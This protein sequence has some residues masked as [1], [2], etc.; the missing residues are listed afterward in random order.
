MTIYRKLYSAMCLGAVLLLFQLPASAQSWQENMKEARQLYINGMYQNAMQVFQKT[1]SQLE[2]QGSAY[3][4]E[5]EEAEGYKLLCALKLGLEGSGRQAVNYVRKYPVSSLGKSIRFE[6]A[7]SYFREEN[8][9]RALMLLESLKP[10][11]I[12]ANE[13]DR[14]LLE[15]GICLMNEGRMIEAQNH[16]MEVQDKSKLHGQAQ[17][18]L[19]FIEYQEGR[20]AQAIEYFN[21]VKESHPKAKLMLAECHFMLKDYPYVR[22]HSD[23]ANLYEGSEKARFARIISESAFALGSNQEAE[24][25]FELYSRQKEL[26]KTDAFY[27]G[28]IAYSQGNWRKAASLFEECIGF[29]DSDSLTQNALY[30]LARCKI[31][32]KDKVAAA[33]AFQ[34]ASQMD[35]NPQV[36]EDA[37]FNYAK[38]S[39]DLWGNADNLY[40]Y[41][42]QYRPDT[43]KKDETYGYIAAK[44]LEENNYEEAI[45]S[46]QMISSPSDKDK[47]NLQ[48]ANFFQGIDL[49]R[50]GRY[51][52]SVKYLED[53][54]SD[55]NATIG[56]LSSYW[57]AESLFRQGK[58]QESLDILSDLQ[59]DPGF[60]GTSEYAVSYFN[61]GYDRLRLKDVEG[62]YR[63]F[64]KYLSL[65]S[66]GGEYVLEARLRQ[67][68]CKFMQRDFPAASSLYS[69]ITSLTAKGT[70]YAPLQEAVS[71]GLM[72]NA[73]KKVEIL[74]KYT[75]DTYRNS[76]KFS[77][78][79][80][81][82]GRTQV[83]LADSKSAEK[84]FRRLVE[85]PSDSLFYGKALIE[86]G[87]L[88][89]NMSDNPK[90]KMY[91]RKAAEFAP[92]EEET[93]TAM[94]A[95]QNICIQEGNPDEFHKWVSSL[96]SDARNMPGSKEDRIR[97]L[98]N[99]AE[100]VFL[101]EKYDAAAKAFERF[102]AEYPDYNPDKTWYYLAEARSMVSDFS[103]AAEAYSHLA[104]ISQG[105]NQTKQYA[106][107]ELG[108]L[109]KGKEYN[110]LILKS[111][112]YMEKLDFAEEQARLISYYKAKSLLAEGDADKAVDL[113][114]DVAEDIQD[115]IGA[116]SA[117]LLVK[118][119]Y[120]RGKYEKVERLVF[121][122]AEQNTPQMYYLAKCY[123]LLGD[124]YF[125]QEDYEQASAVYNS[126]YTSY[127]GDAQI[128][129]T[130]LAKK[131]EA[132]EQLKKQVKKI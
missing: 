21:N 101:A 86:L 115:E 66:D 47:A 20:F 94:N 81:E 122:I 50:Q 106:L 130:A 9:G 37:F 43:R 89:A 49:L 129:E 96:P 114:L 119:A 87:M 79:L 90:A 26:T 131:K 76:E 14:Y 78:A 55:G 33:D 10:A 59:Q 92:S 35:F 75:S 72:G 7:S 48:K 91:L 38:L 110:K 41:L 31:E 8:Y 17:Y 117:Y 15:K 44:C 54:S 53:A 28:Q 24:R 88:Y 73:K 126:I 64:G 93:Q 52:P 19:G 23:D 68:D 1:A 98:F 111:S 118:D 2:A 100:Q 127:Q 62:A 18:Y 77:E 83:Q 128:K 109:F 132:E 69:S 40:K 71:Q 45:K 12:E 57:L 84:T 6:A 65:T 112:S 103:G 46:L 67:A 5:V 85:N 102:I 121:S 80:Y 124:S 32:E 120:D 3:S 97:L 39:F 95:Y 63:D 70:L 30:R 16:F 27:A 105:Q 108:M 60:K 82:L 104:S 74:K 42:E 116:E 34:K 22:A 11:D 13:R 25:W 61:S 123:L 36:K 56:N 29:R 113:L 107:S 58:F 4:K 51:L 125:E 99:S